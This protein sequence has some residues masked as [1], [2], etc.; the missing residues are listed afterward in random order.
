MKQFRPVRCERCGG[1]ATVDDDGNKFPMVS[2]AQPCTCA[3]APHEMRPQ[4]GAK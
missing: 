3:P 2:G 4:E 1:T